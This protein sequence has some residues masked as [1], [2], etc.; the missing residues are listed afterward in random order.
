MSDVGI[1]LGSDSD[2]PK[3]RECFDIL[4]EFG[5]PFEILVS[6]AHRTPEKTRQWVSTARDRGLKV[7][8]A[9]AGGAA[10]LPGVVASHTTLP[11]IG[12]PIETNIA[13]GLDSI[14][15]I[16]QMPGGIP[17]AT[18]PAGKAGGINAALFAVN[19]LSLLDKKYAAKL[20]EYRKNVAEKINA[21]NEKLNTMGYKEYISSL[22]AKK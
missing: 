1:I 9:V 3:V 11:V 18:M 15:S 8:I 16:L 19:I 22:E 12:V 2:L 17:V 20:D 5:I 7:I 6:S 14:L 4:D 13:G 21:R 10:H